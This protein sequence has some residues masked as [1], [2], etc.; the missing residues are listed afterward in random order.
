MCVERLH[1]VAD[2]GFGRL[3]SKSSQ[4][5]ALFQNHFISLPAEG[6]LVLL[7]R[8]PCGSLGWRPDGSM[9]RARLMWVTPPP[10]RSQITYARL[11]KVEQFFELPFASVFSTCKMEII[12]L[13]PKVAV[14]NSAWHNR[15]EI[16]LSITGIGSLI[17]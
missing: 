15:L 16:M 2:I 6:S 3:Q 7:T 8:F 9:V 14:K 10:S 17:N 1:Q 12:N 5:D 4:E 11:H 13:P